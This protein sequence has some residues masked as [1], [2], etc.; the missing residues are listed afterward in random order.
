MYIDIYVYICWN[1]SNIFIEIFWNVY[2]KLSNAVTSFA[3]GK[4]R[5]SM[6]QQGMSTLQAEPNFAKHTAGSFPI[7]LTYIHFKWQWTK[8]FMNC[9]FLAIFLIHLTGYRLL[10]EVILK[11]GWINLC[12]CTFVDVRWNVNK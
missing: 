11:C 3:K 9:D 1:L 5:L 4:P 6:H 12:E 10:Y 2:E 8:S 7:G